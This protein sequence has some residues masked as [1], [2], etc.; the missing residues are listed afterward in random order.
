[1]L[2]DVAAVAEVDGCTAGDAGARVGW[3]VAVYGDGLSGPDDTLREAEA[4]A[5]TPTG[6]PDVGGAA[7]DVTAAGGS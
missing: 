5:G 6:P 3:D 4:E 1:V 2:G 7:E